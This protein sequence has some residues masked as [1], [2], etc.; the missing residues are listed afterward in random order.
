MT[1][2]RIGVRRDIAELISSE[3]ADRVTPLMTK[4]YYR[5][6]VT[7]PEWWESSEA[8][9][10]RGSRREEVSTTAWAELVN[11]LGVSPEEA[12]KALEWLHEK[13]VIDYQVD[14]GERGIKISFE[15]IYS[16]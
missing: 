10:V 16:E 4:I 5:L 12:Q 2:K 15:G 11:W 6:L 1:H 7:P 8:L 9:R 14:Q 3:E 13:K